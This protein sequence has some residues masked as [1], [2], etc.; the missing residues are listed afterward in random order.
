[1]SDINHKQKLEQNIR[2]I[3]DWL[4]S[5][6]ADISAQKAKLKKYQKMLDHMVELEKEGN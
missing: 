6:K 3:N 4:E 2:D 5:N 1:M